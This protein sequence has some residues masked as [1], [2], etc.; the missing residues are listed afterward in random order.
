MSMLFTISSKIHQ[1]VFD[2]LKTGD[3]NL[4]CSTLM[5]HYMETINGYL[6]EHK[7]SAQDFPY[8]INMEFLKENRPF[9]SDSLL[10]IVQN[11]DG[12]I[13]VKNNENF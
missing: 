8:K 1:K 13:V 3:V 4:I 12:K 6:I 10:Y 9:W 11:E 2:A 5:E 7:I